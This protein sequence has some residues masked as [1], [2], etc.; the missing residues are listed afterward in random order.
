MDNS[1]ALLIFNRA[2]VTTILNFK[3]DF[4]ILINNKNKKTI[5]NNEDQRLTLFLYL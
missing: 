1:R 3:I 2:V 4:F 5:N